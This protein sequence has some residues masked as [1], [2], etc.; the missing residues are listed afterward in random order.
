VIL[1]PQRP[2]CWDYRYAPPCL[3]TEAIKKKKRAKKNLSYQIKTDLETDTEQ[4]SISMSSGGKG[5]GGNV[6]GK[7]MWLL[8]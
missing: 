1:L 2:E 8:L 7:Q 4:I 5:C 3:A 6:K